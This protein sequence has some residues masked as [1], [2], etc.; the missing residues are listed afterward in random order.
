M[1]SDS[2]EEKAEKVKAHIVDWLGRNNHQVDDLSV[3]F[4]DGLATLTGTC[5][6]DKIKQKAVIFAKGS[7]LVE[8][9]N[10]D[11]IMVRDTGASGEAPME[12]EVVIESSDAP[13]EEAVEETAAETPASESAGQGG[14]ASAND[15]DSQEYTIQSG[16]SL[17]KIAKQF[18]GDAGKYMIIF[19]ANKDI[20][21]DPNSIFPGQV[22][23]IPAS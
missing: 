20:I 10:A 8:V 9:V 7:D 4:E 6:T 5:D 12:E 21:K 19:E 15:S 13:V 23:R 3:T 16:D 2:N 18:Y 11:G 17:S 14:G 1:F 22:I